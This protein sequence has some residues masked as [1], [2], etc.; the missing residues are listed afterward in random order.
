MKWTDI[1]SKLVRLLWG[2]LLFSMFGLCVEI[3]FTGASAGRG[4]SLRGH[5]SLL[6][7]PV[8]MAAYLVTGGGL[9]LAERWGLTHLAVR[10]PVALVVIYAIEWAFGAAYQSLGL[11]PWHYDHGWASE[12]SGGAVTLYYLPAWTLFAIIVVQV[13]RVV[14][15]VSPH[16]DAAAREELGALARDVLRARVD[17]VIPKQVA[18]RAY[19]L[20][21]AIR[22][23]LPTRA[24]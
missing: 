24:G 9:R 4:G 23:Q 10:I 19:A 15:A 17:P 5:V 16:V 22:A 6:M 12:F 20:A 1:H 8:Y 13:W 11:S 21:A 14:H 18:D 3:V 2:S 7:I